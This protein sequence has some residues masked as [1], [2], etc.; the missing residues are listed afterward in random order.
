MTYLAILEIYHCIRNMYRSTTFLKLEFV[1]KFEFQKLEFFEKKYSKKFWKFLMVMMPG[2]LVK[3]FIQSGTVH[4]L[5][6]LQNNPRK[7]K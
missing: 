2:S 7:E 6:L 3:G 5:T 1:M 4:E